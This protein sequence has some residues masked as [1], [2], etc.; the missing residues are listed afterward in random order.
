MG[1]S[2]AAI[3]PMDTTALSPDLDAAWRWVLG[4]NV[5][6]GLAQDATR[7]RGWSAQGSVAKEVGAF[8]DIYAPLRRTAGVNVLAH[9]GQSIDGYVAL[10]DGES[11]GLSAPENIAHLHRLRALFDVVMIGGTTAQS[12]DPRL[13]TRLV[14][15]PSPVRVVVDPGLKTSPDLG[16]YADSRA[17]TLLF[18]SH[19]AP[20]KEYP[21][22]TRI[23]RVH[24]SGRSF[25]QAAA[26]T[27][28]GLGLRRVFIE[29][30]GR[31]V[32][33]WLT[34]GLLNRLHL[35]VAPVLLG[36]GIPGLV[37]KPC[38]NLEHI[39]QPEVTS[40]AMG[41]DVLFDFVLS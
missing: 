29:G 8:L 20:L 4:A 19:D 7:P 31:L 6:S 17:D 21:Q 41:R 40:H 18:C 39:S 25:L 37:A 1:L 36:A 12:D 5:C 9:L 26:A 35:T 15:G 3:L 16:L 2:R 23:C 22:S 33:A 10:P 30:G 32:S 27:L 38:R 14:D 28:Q 13:T 24:A 11:R 34:E